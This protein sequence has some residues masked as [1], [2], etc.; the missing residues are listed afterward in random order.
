MAI[1]L[2][3]SPLYHPSA[4][5]NLDAN[6]LV[7]K[8]NECIDGLNIDIDTDRVVPRSGTKAFPVPSFIGPVLKFHRYIHPTRG[9]ILFAFCATDIYRYDTTQGW[10]SCYPG[11]GFSVTTWSITNVV[12]KDLG[13]TVV[14]AGC[15]YTRP[16]EGYS[17]A[18]TRVLLIYDNQVGFQV[19]GSKI[20]EH[21]SGNSYFDTGVTLGSSSTISFEFEVDSSPTPVGYFCGGT[22]TFGNNGLCLKL[23]LSTVN[24][25]DIYFNGVVYFHKITIDLDTRYKIRIDCA[26]GDIY[27]NGV[28]DGSCGTSLVNSGFNMLFHYP[29]SSTHGVA[30]TQQNS[31]GFTVYNFTVGGTTYVYHASGYFFDVNTPAN[32]IFDRDNTLLI[33]NSSYHTWVLSGSGTNEYYLS[34]TVASDHYDA[35]PQYEPLNVKVQGVAY[36]AGTAGVLAE[37][38][39][40][41][42]DNDTL[43]YNTVYIRLDSGVYAD[44]N[45]N[46]TADTDVIAYGNTTAALGFYTQPYDTGESVDVGFQDMQLKKNAYDDEVLVSGMVIVGPP[47]IITASLAVARTVVPGTAYLVVDT[48]GVVAT[49]TLKE[50][51]VEDTPATHERTNLWIPVDDAEVIYG[52]TSY[53]DLENG[54]VSIEFIQNTYNGKDLHIYYQYEDDVDYK[55]IH[56]S[57]YH[58]ALVLANTAEYFTTNITGPVQEWR[59][60]PFRTRWSMQNNIRLFREND[61]QDLALDDI[62]PI[63]G[64]RSLETEASSTIVGPLYFLKH[65]SIVRGTYNQNYNLDPSLPVPMFNFEIAYSEGM[66]STNTA[67]PID[68]MMFYLGRNDVYA[69][70]GYKRI[71]LTHDQSTGNSRVQRSIVDNLNINY[72]YRNFGLYDEVSRKYYLF[73]VL[74]T[75]SSNY[76]EDCFVYDLD[77][78]YWVRHTYSQISAAIDT[79]VSFEGTIDGLVGTIDG[80]GAVAIDDLTNN[81]SKSLLFSIG[82]YTYYATKAKMDEIDIN[83]TEFDSYFITRDFLSQTLENEDRVQRVVVEAKGASINISHNANY[84]TV[85]SDFPAA[86]TLKFGNK[87]SRQVYHPDITVTAIRFLIELSEGSEFRW[88]Q[89]FSKPQELLND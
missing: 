85:K 72:L 89:V 51:V 28:Y 9:S 36:A 30:T 5:V 37:G 44:P 57:N 2:Q 12:D 61:Y 1:E 18:S 58:N 52:E 54:N 6:G 25:L 46:N 35:F 48:V 55:P 62:T 70:N 29:N 88:M 40:D 56:V 50:H 38:E 11:T 60:T 7:A 84:E 20:V 73:V 31:L 66:E 64:L 86:T 15:V 21:P 4:G 8:P 22:N 76:P 63:L 49:A 34:S 3:A 19:V 87:Y 41:W 14:A 33:S 13:S 17:D 68:G 43:G 26:T 45:V 74:N 32:K 79:E 27:V 10:I 75:S 71:S 47:T 69:F 53:I 39:W 78:N 67:V 65:N 83:N 81:A 77:R 82:D 42:G 24:T 23:T 16:T 59:Y 80:L